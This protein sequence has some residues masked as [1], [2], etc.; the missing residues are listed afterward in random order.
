MSIAAA[1]TEKNYHSWDKNFYLAECLVDGADGF[2][3]GKQ[4]PVIGWNNGWHIFGCNR[5]GDPVEVIAHNI[6]GEPLDEYQ[7]LTAWYADSGKPCKKDTDGQAHFVMYMKDY[8]TEE[9]KE[10]IYRE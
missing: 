7:L 5:E 4:Y 2:E 6:G 10:K 8:Y 9:E 1:Y 3:C